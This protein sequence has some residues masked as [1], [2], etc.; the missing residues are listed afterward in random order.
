MLLPYR[1]T[2][3]EDRTVCHCGLP[4]RQPNDVSYLCMRQERNYLYALMASGV[5]ILGIPIYHEYTLDGP[6]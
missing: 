4:S 3:F 1:R 5:L 2:C 6:Q